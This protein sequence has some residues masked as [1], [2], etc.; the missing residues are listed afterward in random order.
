MSAFIDNFIYAFIDNID[1]IKTEYIAEPPV[2]TGAVSLAPLSSSAHYL[3]PVSARRQ[4]SL[5]CFGL[6]GS[7]PSS[8]SF[9]GRAV[10]VVLSDGEKLSF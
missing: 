2:G 10:S 6:K 3:D 4:E 8:N 5:L 7:E 9:I 1:T